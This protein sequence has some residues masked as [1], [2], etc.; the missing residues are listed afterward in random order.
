[1]ADPGQLARGC[2]CRIWQQWRSGVI[3]MITDPR[4]VDLAFNRLAKPKDGILERR[5]IAACETI[6]IMM[7]NTCINYQ[8]MPPVRGDHL[9]F[10]DTGVVIYANVCGRAIKF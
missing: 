9:A 8:I 4:G 5:F 3:P 10:G 2:L 7:T 6:G 1:M